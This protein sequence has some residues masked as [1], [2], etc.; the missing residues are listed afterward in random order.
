M[1]SVRFTEILFQLGCSEA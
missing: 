1:Q